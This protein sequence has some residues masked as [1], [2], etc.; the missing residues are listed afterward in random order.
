MLSHVRLR[1]KADEQEACCRIV[2]S[3]LTP[4]AFT[5]SETRRLATDYA[6]RRF[7]DKSARR[8]RPR[9][10]VN[11]MAVNN[12]N[13]RD[14]LGAYWLQ[15]NALWDKRTGDENRLLFNILL[16]FGSLLDRGIG[17]RCSGKH[18]GRHQNYGAFPYRPLHKQN[19]TREGTVCKLLKR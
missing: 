9:N 10:P 15:L 6:N 5:C 8:R 18:A 13:R 12:S 19:Y 3:N 14:C 4:S 16:T 17:K 7:V 2:S 11:L 1:G